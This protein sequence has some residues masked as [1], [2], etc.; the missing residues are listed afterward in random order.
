MITW[1]TKK[2]KRRKNNAPKTKLKNSILEPTLHTG[3]YDSMATRSYI[4]ALVKICVSN[5]I[6]VYPS[7][8][9]RQIFQCSKGKCHLKKA[10]RW[11]E[12]T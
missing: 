3:A 6:K 12:V 7:R 1:W 4:F 8:Q 9:I 2:A 5:L 11:R 10:Q